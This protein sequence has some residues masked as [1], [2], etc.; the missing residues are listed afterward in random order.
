MDND[1]RKCHRVVGRDDNA[2][3]YMILHLS[4]THKRLDNTLFQP[5]ESIPK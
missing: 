1:G 4:P 5:Q 2:W 3:K